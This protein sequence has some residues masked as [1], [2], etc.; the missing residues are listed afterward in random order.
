VLAT[1][2]KLI[3]ALE[4][5][6]KRWEDVAVKCLSILRHVPV[7]QRNEWITLASTSR[8]RATNLRMLVENVSGI[9]LPSPPQLAPTNPNLPKPTSTAVSQI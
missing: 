3:L 5:D 7:G 6:A 1:H 4:D 8:E 9:P 2:I